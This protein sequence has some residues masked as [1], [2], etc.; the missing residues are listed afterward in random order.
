MHLDSRNDGVSKIRLPIYAPTFKASPH[1][2]YDG[3]RT[4]G[5]LA[6]IVLP[7]GVE[8]W[9]VTDYDA[10]RSLFVDYRLSKSST[11]A[12]TNWHQN[13]V[14]RSSSGQSSPV[15]DHL[16]TVDPPSH[17][18]LRKLVAQSFTK[19]SIER[20]QPRVAAIVSN[21]LDQLRSGEVLDFVEHVALPIPLLVVCELIGAPEEDWPELLKWSK[22]LMTAN[23]DEQ[24]EIVNAGAEFK[25]YL[26]H[27]KDA[28]SLHPDSTLMSELVDA[29]N[30]GLMSESE[31]FGMGFILISAGHE[32]TTSLLSVGL[33]AM[34][35]Q[36][37]C[38]QHLC[39]HPA[40]V[41][42]IVDELLRYSTPVEVATPRFAAEDI[43]I[44]GV[45]IARGD[46]V[47]LGLAAACWDPS[48]FDEAQC[49]R[50]DR[51]SP[52]QTAFGYGVHYC[53]GSHLAKLEAVETFLALSQRAPDLELA[54]TP[55]EWRWRPGLIMRSLER[56]DVR[57]GS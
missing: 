37:D 15:F 44:A 19:K 18:R 35:E 13:H 3:L 56:L 42:L 4:E 20:L 27:R 26:A 53:L 12:S 23:E 38:W 32:T 21:Q 33:A 10:V 2:F 24:E 8:A 36:R 52:P 22:L 6:R 29:C 5:P 45:T 9:M 14:N 43:S 47:F 34:L 40:D 30:Q 50:L 11:H 46:V 49:L 54:S 16:L 51:N 7:N 39:R 31:Y 57:V 1:E 41:G 28:L 48:K 25:H 55:A 17:T